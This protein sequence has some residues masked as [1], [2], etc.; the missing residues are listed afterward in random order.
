MRNIQFSLSDTQLTLKI[1]GKIYSGP[2]KSKTK[3]PLL[4]AKSK[5]NTTTCGTQSEMKPRLIYLPIPKREDSSLQVFPWVVDSLCSVTLMCTHGTFSTPFRSSLTAAQ[6]SETLTGPNG[7]KLKSNPIQ[8]TSVSRATQFVSFQDVSPQF[9]TT[10]TQEL[11]TLV[12]RRPKPAA[13]LERLTSNQPQWNWTLLLRTLSRLLLKRIAT[14][15]EEFS[16]EL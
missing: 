1:S 10:D 11:A 3:T 8:S 9:A 4:A 6:E 7:W 15:L 12:T 5:N 16:T 14:K 2:S 13:Q